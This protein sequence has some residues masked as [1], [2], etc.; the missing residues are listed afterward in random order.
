MSN[1]QNTQL[2]GFAKTEKAEYLI[3]KLTFDDRFAASIVEPV[4]VGTVLPSSVL[5]NRIWI[6]QTQ[7]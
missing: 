1:E 7:E 3:Y 2:L 6:E 5:K 4:P